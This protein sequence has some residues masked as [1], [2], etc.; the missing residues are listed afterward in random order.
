[1]VV[2]VI[3]VSP[4][5]PCWLLQG[6]HDSARPCEVQFSKLSRTV[7]LLLLF[8]AAQVAVNLAATTRSEMLLAFAL[9]SVLQD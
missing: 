6:V 9:A 3:L 8:D 1:V 7:V 5:E 4:H 2:F